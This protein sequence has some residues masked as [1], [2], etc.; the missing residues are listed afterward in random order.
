[1]AWMAILVSCLR[2][3]QVL[4][5]QLTAIS[6]PRQAQSSCA[7]CPQDNTSFSSLPSAILG[8]QGVAAQLIHKTT[9]PKPD[10]EQSLDIAELEHNTGRT[11]ADCIERQLKS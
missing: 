5:D 2:D 8:T 6:D 4:A 9:Y 11:R 1:M 10:V 7:T 3:N